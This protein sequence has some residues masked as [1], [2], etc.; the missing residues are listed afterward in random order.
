MFNKEIIVN[1]KAFARNIINR[2]LLER[3]N[4]DKIIIINKKSFKKKI[5]IIFL[6]TSLIFTNRY[7]INKKDINII[8]SKKVNIFS[9]KCYFSPDNSNLKI[10]HL[11][12]TRFMIEFW[13]KYNFDKIIYNESYI[14]NGLRV[15][16]KYLLPSLE[17]Q[18]CKNFIW[19]LMLGDKANMT[20]IQSLIDFETSFKI[21]IIFKNSM[22][23]Y[24]KNI[25]KNFD[26]LITSRIDYDDRIYYDAVNDVRKVIN[27]NKPILL[28]GYNRGVIYFETNNKYYYYEAMLNNEGAWSVFASLITILNKL[29]DIYIIYDLGGHGH[30][31]KTI[32][33]L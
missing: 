2:K 5:I 10:I 21:Q 9:E 25:T 3:P 7:L 6:L 14:Q 23:E 17:N 16:K 33:T 28:Y 30:V 1:Y 32:L 4:F 27:V 13:K 26:V 19:L 20:Y 11:I 15:M 29:N 18:S 8:N 24:L 22:K 31:R 12:I